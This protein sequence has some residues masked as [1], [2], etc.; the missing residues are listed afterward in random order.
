MFTLAIAHLFHLLSI[1]DVFIRIR[2]ET[3]IFRASGLIGQ[4]SEIF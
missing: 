4:F 3:D 2:S 1:K